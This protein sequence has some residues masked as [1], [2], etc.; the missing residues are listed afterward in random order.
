MIKIIVQKPT[1]IIDQYCFVAFMAVL[2]A[3]LQYEKDFIWAL[4]RINELGF[5]VSKTK[6]RDVYEMYSAWL[7][8]DCSKKTEL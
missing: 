6:N 3:A 8:P 2:A 1:L 4:Q 5:K 7:D